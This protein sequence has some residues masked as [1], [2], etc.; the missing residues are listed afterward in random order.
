MATPN[1]IWALGFI[2]QHL[3][4][5]NY[6]LGKSYAEFINSGSDFTASQWM[7]EPR[8]QISS[9]QTST[10]GSYATTS[11]YSCL[12]TNAFFEF[13]SKPQTVDV[14][15]PVSSESTTDSFEFDLK[16]QFESNNYFS[17]FESKPNKSSKSNPQSGRKPSLKISPPTKTGW[18]NF[19][20]QKKDPE[21]QN[22]N[23]KE[24]KTHYRGVRQRPWGKFAAEIRDPNRKGSRVWLGTF[25]TAIDAARAYDRAAFKMRG[26]KAILNFPLEAGKTEPAAD[27]VASDKKRRRDGEIEE[28]KQEVKVVKT[29]QNE[30]VKDVVLTPSTCKALWEDLDCEPKGIFNVPLLSPLS[31]HPPFGFPQLMVI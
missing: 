18:L 11:D 8:V 21:P 14:V 4:G 28:E 17:E 25:D 15:A 3:F 5:E 2:E 19:T 26:S 20:G 22:S 27:I 16:P 29:E 10:S 9:S 13:D 6:P 30:T 12:N 31:P 23:V 7:E 1:E 24:E